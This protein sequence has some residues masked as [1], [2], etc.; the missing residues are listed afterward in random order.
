M[1]VTGPASVRGR[2]EPPG[3]KS[4][5]HRA[6]ILGALADG[7][8]TVRG[9]SDGRDVAHTRGA[10]EALGVEIAA[11]ADG[12]V[13]I[14]GGTLA[15]PKGRLDLGNSGTGMRLLAGVVAARP[16]RTVL[17]GD[18][19]LCGRPM[20]RI[21]VPLTAM[22][23]SVGGG[24]SRCL[25]PLTIDG[26]SLH[27]VVHRPE[28]ASAQVKGAVLLAG[29][30]ASGPTT[31]V[32]VTPTRA[33]TEELLVAMGAEVDLDANGV[34][35]HP[36]PLDP[37][38]LDVPGDPS[39]AAFWVVAS[40]LC[41]DSEVTLDHVYL[42][43]AR[44]GFLDVL[45][46]MGAD[47]EVDREAGTLRARTGELRGTEVDGRD[48]A[49]L[50]DEIPVLAVAAAVAEG[51]TRFRDAGELRAKES[52]RMAT[53]VAMLR[54][55]GAD[56]DVEGDD[57]V[58]AGGATLRPAALD[59]DGDH[60]IAMAGAVGALTADGDSSIDGWDV[61][62]TSYPGFAADLERLRSRHG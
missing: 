54:A 17:T 14:A 57:L 47:V 41:P 56:C 36:G 48:I 58:I 53:T 49:G 30:E 18:A 59:A 40:L 37:L 29:L 50:V 27:G 42:G 52:D 11:D 8:S 28:V 43:P 2:L 9:L 35:V 26:R 23:A 45:R 44:D 38:D 15:A 13:R 32:E 31:V 7:V 51:P 33:H 21:A 12:K 62:A 10:L 55:M 16:W 22:G 25:P 1:Q 46:A 39:Q 24:G 5:S 19:S 4:I 60:R 34:T 61:V 20:D 6:L 3:D